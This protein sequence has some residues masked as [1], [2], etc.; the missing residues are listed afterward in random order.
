MLYKWSC[1]H[2]FIKWLKVDLCYLYC[3]KCVFCAC[4]LYKYTLH[5]FVVYLPKNM[6]SGVAWYVW[7]VVCFYSY[8]YQQQPRAVDG[9]SRLSTLRYL[10]A[11]GGS[12]SSL[13][14]ATGLLRCPG[15][16][17]FCLFRNGFK[18]VRFFLHS[19][20]RVEKFHTYHKYA[21]HIILQFST[22]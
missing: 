4:C 22:S 9:E 16:F 10:T 8:V 17:Y 3:K 2:A 15:S 5:A 12:A 7:I 21:L 1:I 13:L 11:F 6:Y 19:L 18:A 20:E 14:I